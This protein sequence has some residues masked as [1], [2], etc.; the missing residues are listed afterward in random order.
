MVS[1]HAWGQSG[2]GP[3]VGQK[4]RVAAKS[5]T[6]FSCHTDQLFRLRPE[7]KGASEHRYVV[8]GRR[9]I[10]GEVRLSV[11]VD[12]HAMT[13]S[14]QSDGEPMRAYV[15]GNVGQGNSPGSGAGGR[16]DTTIR[17]TSSGDVFTLFAG[18]DNNGFDHSPVMTT[19]AL[20]TTPPSRWMGA[21]RFS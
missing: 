8:G 12:S 19:T 17:G 1:S 5:K 13:L 18:Y 20:T 16:A 15:L 10:K 7:G 9:A 3:I 6:L 11:D 2:H 4:A 14:L 21:P